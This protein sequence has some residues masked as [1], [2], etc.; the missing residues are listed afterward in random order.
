MNFIQGVEIK[1]TKERGRGVFA[2]KSLKKGE[3][4]IVENAIA[5]VESFTV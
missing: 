5:E 2:A 4:I 3:L 1:L